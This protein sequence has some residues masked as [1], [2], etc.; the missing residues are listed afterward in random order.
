MYICFSYNEYWVLVLVNYS[1]HD[2][3]NFLNTFLKS[4]Q[5]AKNECKINIGVSKNQ[6]GIEFQAENFNK[7][8][9]ALEMAKKKSNGVVFYDKLDIYKV[10]LNTKERVF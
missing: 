8:L 6:N 1:D 4:E 5:S 2:I 10:L 7:A 3:D 9:L